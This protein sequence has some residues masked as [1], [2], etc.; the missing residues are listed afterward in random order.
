VLVD[1]S[2]HVKWAATSESWKDGMKI[3]AGLEG[4]ERGVVRAR[5]LRASDWLCRAWRLA[6]S[7]G[8]GPTASAIA[9][10]PI[11][12]HPQPLS[13]CIPEVASPFL[14][15]FLSV[16]AF[17]SSRALPTVLFSIRLS[18]SFQALEQASHHTYL[19]L[20][21]LVPSPVLPSPPP[22][23]TSAP[24]PQL[25]WESLCG[26]NTPVSSPL[27]RPAVSF[28]PICSNFPILRHFKTLS[29]PACGH[30]STASSSGTLSM[31]PCATQAVSSACPI[32]CAP[33]VVTL[34]DS[35]SIQARQTG[36]RIHHTHC[37]S[38]RAAH[39]LD[40]NRPLHNCIRVPCSMGQRHIHSS[41]LRGPHRRPDHTSIYCHFMVSGSSTLRSP[42]S[43]HC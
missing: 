8:R 25:Q 21:L 37:Q 6:S 26:T 13:G 30:S 41:K 38:A 11:T 42:C 7:T 34:A 24:Q 27:P 33:L 32:P 17:W 20:S 5:A 39:L 4:G 9:L 12:H 1:A 18:S 16:R 43:Q 36:R 19:S 15:R 28:E 2:G 10:C 23:P 40:D 22:T 29:G 31:A 3:E 35:C 14:L